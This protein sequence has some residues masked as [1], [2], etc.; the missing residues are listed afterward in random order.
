MNISMNDE[1]K[2]FGQAATNVPISDEE[3]S[4]NERIKELE[5]KVEENFAGWQRARADY[6]NLKKEWEKKQ[7][8]FMTD[9]KKILLWEL[10]PIYDHLKQAMN[11]PPND[12]HFLEWRRGIE[13]IKSQYDALLK[14]WN[15]EPVATT[16]EKFNPELHEAIDSKDANNEI[17]TQEVRGGYKVD[18]QLLYP[19]KVIVG[20]TGDSTGSENN[21]PKSQG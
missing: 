1:N 13:Q 15:V 12:S 16:G 18:G 10:L 9:A 11:L 5:R 2:T 17:I 4:V 3:T 21:L 19:A 7:T 6:Q 14:R 20:L 8:Q